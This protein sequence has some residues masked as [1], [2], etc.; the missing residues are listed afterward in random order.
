MHTAPM[1]L[2]RHWVVKAPHSSH[3]RAHPCC[4][5][6]WWCVT[7][8]ICTGLLQSSHVIRSVSTS[9]TNPV[10]F[11]DVPT[12]RFLQP[13]CAQ[14]GTQNSLVS[15]PDCARGSVAI[16]VDGARCRAIASISSGVGFRLA[17]TRLADGKGCFGL[18]HTHFGKG[19]A[20]SIPNPG[21]GNRFR[22]AVRAF[23]RNTRSKMPRREID[24]ISGR[25]LDQR[26][27]SSILS[28]HKTPMKCAMAVRRTAVR[29]P[30][31]SAFTAAACDV[32]HL[33]R[34]SAKLSDALC[35]CSPNVWILQISFK[36]GAAG[37][38]F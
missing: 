9:I 24:V 34:R 28:S 23:G 20:S 26:W 10:R 33:R 8:N 32:C 14:C 3:T 36:T 30:I 31:N 1:P 16:A 2:R 6:T 7:L 5:L 35:L 21:A 17:R 37:P 15:P 12:G 29:A 18:V 11:R 25:C 38:S 27:R 22:F 13:H 19:E 4:V